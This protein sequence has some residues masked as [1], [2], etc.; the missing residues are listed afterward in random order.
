[1]Y[2]K[3]NFVLY[4]NLTGNVFLLNDQGKVE[5]RGDHMDSISTLGSSSYYSNYSGY[6]NSSD[7]S[8]EEKAVS[9]IGGLQAGT[10]NVKDGKSLLNISDGAA[11]QITD[12]LQ[13]IRELAVRASNGTMSASDRSDIQSQIDNYKKGIN[14]I[15]GTT[16]FN[17]TY[18][19]NGKNST[20]DIVSDGNKTTIGISGSNS[21]VQSLGIEDFDV[22]KGFDIDK[23]DNAIKMVSDQRAKNGAQYNALSAQ[24]AYNQTAIHNTF[25]SSSMKDELE[26][27]VEQ[28]Q[29]NKQGQF[30]E[31]VRLM[32]QKKDEEQAKQSTTNLFV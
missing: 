13:S 19:M 10:E 2:T 32:M 28:N 21:L 20:I 12:Y 31:N 25:A 5:R 7:I 23:V 27:I 9:Q 29:K 22:R 6:I 1:M 16:K 4:Y 8:I 15:A 17:E 26:E 14:D 3:F 11:A 18:L 24:E 30:L